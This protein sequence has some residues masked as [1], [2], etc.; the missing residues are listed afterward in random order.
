MPPALAQLTAELP[1]PSCFRGPF[2]SIDLLLEH[3]DRLAL[4][5]NGTQCRN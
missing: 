3:V 5:N 2:V 4:A 1:P